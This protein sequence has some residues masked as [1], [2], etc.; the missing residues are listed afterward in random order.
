MMLTIDSK[1]L[2]RGLEVVKPVVTSNKIVPICDNIIIRS[3]RDCIALI[4][5]NINHSIIT[6]V[7]CEVR[8]KINALIPFMDLYNIC[9]GL[10]D[11]SI[12]IE[13]G[14][15]IKITSV[16]G[17]YNITDIDDITDFPKVEVIQPNHELQLPSSYIE[18][19]KARSLKFLHSDEVNI[20]YHACFDFDNDGL[21][22]VGAN[23][24]CLSLL[25]V[26]C[27]SEPKKYS[28]DRSTIDLLQV[29]SFAG[30]INVKF[31]DNKFQAENDDTILVSPLV[32]SEFPEYK[33][34]IGSPT[35]SIEVNRISFLN[36][37]LR[38]NKFSMNTTVLLTIGD[39][40]KISS[41]NNDYGKD[42]EE[43]IDIVD[44]QGFQEEYSLAFHCKFLIDFIST[45]NSQ[46]ILLKGDEGKPVYQI[47]E[48]GSEDVFLL[49]SMKI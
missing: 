7:P 30:E 27:K 11:Q 46:T 32:D 18:T 17:C 47:Q 8:S 45:C 24:D 19:I 38:S 10:P 43:R 12:T 41:I 21:N 29:F 15:N 42:F 28:I 1:K 20:K 40:L 39:E 34:L 9:K 6:Q 37:L 23:N 5:S 14:K 26:P 35:C 36:S 16:N 3:D 2:L 48:P 22:V 25:R 13:F 49:V 33:H 44:N 4:G 31:S